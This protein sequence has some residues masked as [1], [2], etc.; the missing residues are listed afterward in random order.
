MNWKYS[1]VFCFHNKIIE[2]CWGSINGLQKSKI[3]FDNNFSKNNKLILNEMNNW[4]A[5]QAKIYWISI[6]C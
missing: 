2:I 6:I 1:K 4:H 5:M 3:I